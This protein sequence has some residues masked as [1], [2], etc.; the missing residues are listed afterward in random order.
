MEAFLL[1]FAKLTTSG[2]VFFVIVV[3]SPSFTNLIRQHTLKEVRNYNREKSFYLKLSIPK[4]FSKNLA[5]IFLLE[6]FSLWFNLN[7]FF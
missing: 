2:E 4:P 3:A 6:P 7:G 5:T 1:L